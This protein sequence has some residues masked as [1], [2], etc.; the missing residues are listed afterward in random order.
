MNAFW[1]NPEF[2]RNLWLELSPQRLLLMPGLIALILLVFTWEFSELL[3]EALAHGASSLIQLGFICITIIWGSMQAG[4]ALSQEFSDGTWDNQRMSGLTAWQMVWGKWL[5]STIYAWYGGAILLALMIVTM[6]LAAAPG[7]RIL[8]FC[9]SLVS[10]AVLLQTSALL[11]ALVSWHRKPGNTKRSGMIVLLMLLGLFSLASLI[12]GSPPLYWFGEHESILWWGKS[13]PGLNFIACMFAML[14]IW[15]LVGLWQAMRRELL[16]RNRAWCWPAFLLFWMGWSAGFVKTREWSS[17]FTICT[18]LT[19]GT[20]YLLLFFERKDQ[21]M[22]LRLIAA[23]KNR[24]KPLIRHLLP[25]WLT[26]FALALALSL[27][28]LASLR[29]QKLSVLLALLSVAAFVTRDVAWILR[30]NMA[31]DARRA[32]SAAAI[33][34]IVAYGVLPVL[35]GLISPQ[36]RSVLLPDLVSRT[37]VV[38]DFQLIL[39]GLVASLS[40]AALA[41]W[42]LYRRWR[43]VFG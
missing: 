16:L 1:R 27:V 20:V 8:F 39:I 35:A 38:H 3:L 10:L 21:G 23:C 19:W 36:L 32:D 37:Q 12:I 7:D 33:S 6:N 15:S 5:G 28:T 18:L 24:D 42:L 26:S 30:L 22:W 41:V 17:F 31:P 14:A 11:S 29:E 34:L 40:Q 2:R 13:W 4:N 9:V 25:S 43:K